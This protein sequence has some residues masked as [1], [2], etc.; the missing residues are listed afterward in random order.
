M[1]RIVVSAAIGLAAA[2]FQASGFAADAAR[3][4][5]EAKE[6]G[7]LK[8]HDVDKKKVGPSFKDAGA[9]LKGKKA[10]EAMAEMKG[11]PVHKTALKNVSDGS[12]KEI[13]GWIQSM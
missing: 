2:A 6:H 10:E 8:C 13:M 9:K 11:K 3:G 12:L 4:M 7:C 1:N 5:E